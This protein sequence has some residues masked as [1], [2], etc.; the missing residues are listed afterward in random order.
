M[1]S[2]EIVFWL[3][4]LCV[5]YVSAGYPLLLLVLARLSRRRTLRSG[6]APKS[7][8]MVMAA[9][10]EESVIDSRLQELTRRLA[11]SGLKGEL[12]VVCDGATDATA[13]LARA[14]QQAGVRVIELASRQGKAAALSA[15]CAA[16]GNEVLVLVDARQRLAPT[17]IRCL[18]EN[19][20]DASVGAVS[21]DL[22]LE[23]SPGILAGVGW[24]WRYEK[25]LRQQE[26]RVHSVVGVTGAI[27]GLRRELFRPIPAGTIL[28]DVYWP[29]QVVLQGFRVVHDTRAKAYDRLPDRA[30]QEFRRKVRTL[31]GNYQLLRLLPAALLPWRNPIWLQFVSHKLLRLAVPWALLAMLGA[32][33]VLEHPAY[34]A[35]LAAQG[36]F[37]VLGLAGMLRQV[38]ARSR[39]TA[40]AASFLLLNA[41][42]WTAFWVWITGNAGRAWRR[43]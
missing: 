9:H 41:A 33:L 25:W 37:Y 6:T 19:F 22:V 23:E 18:V 28:D 14:H 17:A 39:L 12:I 31:A 38:A 27:S 7:V 35:L 29:L 10:N 1:S 5:A 32:G 24:Y 15:G 34:R 11:E 2:A 13:A 3:S 21:G 4:A 36:A 20:N 16:A 42:A 8:S 40:A 30:R 43:T 26:S